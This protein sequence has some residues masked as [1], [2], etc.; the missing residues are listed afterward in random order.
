MSAQRRPAILAL[1]DGT[2]YRGEA[3]GAVGTACAEVVFHTAMSGYTE[4]LTDPSYCG[5]FVT[6]TYPLIGNYGVR[7]EDFESARFQAEG[8]IVRH[9]T[10][11]AGRAPDLEPLLVERGVVGIQELDT[12]T[13][14][15]PPCGRSSRGATL[16]YLVVNRSPTGADQSCSPTWEMVVD[17]DPVRCS[18]A[19]GSV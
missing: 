2:I 17:S 13:L 5:Q 9:G 8:L 4:I 16:S 1:E 3:Y 15:R 18:I 10:H 14:V 12:R 19:S 7:D 11:S 6:F